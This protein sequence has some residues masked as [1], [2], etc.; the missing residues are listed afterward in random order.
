MTSPIQSLALCS[1]ITVLCST[2]AACTTTI[3]DNQVASISANVNGINLQ[4]AKLTATRATPPGIV[5][6]AAVVPGSTGTLYLTLRPTGTG[7]LALKG[8]TN[9]GAWHSNNVQYLTALSGG[10]GTVTITEFNEATRLI[11]GTFSFVAVN[12]EGE[13]IEVTDGSFTNVKWAEE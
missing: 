3:V 5:S 13:H 11:S 1:A 8:T 2:L 7:T 9:T 6:I 10:S 4:A 12:T